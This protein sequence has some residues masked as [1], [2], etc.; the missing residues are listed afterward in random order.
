MIS[1]GANVGTAHLEK[2]KMSHGDEEPSA[3]RIK[4]KSV[5]EEDAFGEFD[6]EEICV[7]GTLILPNAG[8]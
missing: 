7:R 2:Q 5:I 8:I 1:S 4:T 6:S 3:K